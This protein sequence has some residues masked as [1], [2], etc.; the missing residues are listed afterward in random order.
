M[1]A[2]QRRPSG[3]PRPLGSPAF[4]GMSGKRVSAC[5]RDA[6]RW[7]CRLDEARPWSRWAWTPALRRPAWPRRRPAACS[8]WPAARRASAWP[9]GV[10]RGRASL[11]RALVGGV[12]LGQGLFADALVRR[13]RGATAARGRRSCSRSTSC[14]ARARLAGTSLARR[15]LGGSR[16]AAALADDHRLLRL[17]PARLADEL[18]L[19]DLLLGQ[20]DAR[21][22]S[23]LPVRG[24]PRR[25]T[26]P[27]PAWPGP[28]A[29]RPRP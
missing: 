6:D 11:C 19:L 20:Q 23:S 7:A 14:R 26:S 3:S 28:S 18:L 16:L 21:P 15:R 27:P 22:G 29:A 2:A 25:C 8:R 13:P 9:A 10:L 17:G 24:T 12:L 5:R 1:S 4:A